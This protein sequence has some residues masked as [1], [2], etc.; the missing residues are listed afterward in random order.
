MSKSVLRMEQ[1]EKKKGWRKKM[2]KKWERGHTKRGVARGRGGCPCVYQRII[3]LGRSVRNKKKSVFTQV[4]VQ[5][6]VKR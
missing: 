3:Q 2:E 1:K 5:K 4:G 6:V